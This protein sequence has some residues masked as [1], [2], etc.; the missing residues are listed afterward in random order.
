MYFSSKYVLVF[1]LKLFKHYF[2]LTHNCLYH[3]DFTYSIYS[4]LHILKIYFSNFIA[5]D[6]SLLISVK[7]MWF[8]LQYDV[9][10]LSA[11]FS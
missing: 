10:G 8:A 11:I 4:R 3:N 2:L 6:F 9:D 1:S 7:R 5:K